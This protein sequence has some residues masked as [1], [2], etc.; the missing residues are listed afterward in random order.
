VTGFFF[1]LPYHGHIHPCL[2]VIGELIRRGEH[3]VAYAPEEFRPMLE[4]LGAEFRCFPYRQSDKRALVTMACWQLR[5]AASCMASLVQDARTQGAQYVLVDPACHWGYALAQHL[6]LPLIALHSTFPMA[7]HRISHLRSILLDLRRAPD[8]LP[9][10]LRF[11]VLDRWFSGKWRI[12]PL[13]SPIALVQPR[14]ALVQ[15][16]LAHESM[17]PDA[18]NGSYH[19][20]G[21]CLRKR[22]STRGEPLPPVSDRPLVYVSLGTIWNDRADF[23]RLCIAAYRDSGYQV[24]ISVGTSVAAAS[25]PAP[26]DHIHIRAHVDQMAVLERAA[27]FVS[28]GGMN[29]LSEGLHAG[30]P[31]VLFPQAND[32]F[33][34]S[35][36]LERRGVAVLLRPETLSAQAIRDATDTALQDRALLA[37]TR[38]VRDQ[39]RS[40]GSGASRAA[41]LV[42]AALQGRGSAPPR[43]DQ[44]AGRFSEIP[45]AT[46]L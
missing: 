35:Q 7:F 43:P 32:Q 1:A 40:A 19:F 34:L 26:Q 8:V 6:S 14:H 5:V 42:C 33:A 21:P 36:L 4:E 44:R 29:S 22:G 41:D 2:P 38:E 28:H 11:L 27:V 46:A 15:L 13:V 37:R 12:P 16:V 30:V 23:Y 10:V 45:H 31:L 25:L 39:M 18:A 3:I 9:T 24:L 17:Q 20:V